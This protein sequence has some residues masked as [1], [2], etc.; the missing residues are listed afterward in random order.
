M[1]F[2]L[3][4]FIGDFSKTS[5]YFC[6]FVVLMLITTFLIIL[7]HNNYC[8]NHKLNEYSLSYLENEE[9][10]KNICKYV[11]SNLEKL[12]YRKWFIPDQINGEVEY[13]P[14]YLNN[15][16]HNHNAQYCLSLLKILNKT[17]EIYDIYII[18]LHPKAFF[19]CRKHFKEQ[20][21]CISGIIPITQSKKAHIWISGKIKTFKNGIILY[22]PCVDHSIISESNNPV[23][24]IYFELK[25]LPSM[26]LILCDDTPKEI[27][28]QIDF[29]MNELKNL[30][31]T[32]NTS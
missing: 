32:N 9:N 13:A 2:N 14:I 1:T 8:Y 5:L 7:P 4:W 6:T 21:H 26:P 24:Y 30:N 12:I 11:N 15:I 19:K 22:D 16:I 25:R 29:E 20:S 3:S 10:K 18:K 27:Q 31:E 23:Y 28:K 17:S